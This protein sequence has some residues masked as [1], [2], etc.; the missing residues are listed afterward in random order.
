MHRQATPE[1][2]RQFSLCTGQFLSL[3]FRTTEVTAMGMMGVGRQDLTQHISFGSH[4]TVDI[5]NSIRFLAW[6]PCRAQAQKLYVS[7]LQTYRV[8]CTFWAF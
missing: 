8:R 3:L 6:R 2:S 4:E 5:G 7:A 1:L